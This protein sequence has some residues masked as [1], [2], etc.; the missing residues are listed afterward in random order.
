[1]MKNILRFLPVA[2]LFFGFHAN[3]Q[4][5]FA[6]QISVPSGYAP[7]EAI[8]PPSPLTTQVLFVGGVDL[9]QTTPTYGNPAG[10]A[11]AKEWHDFIGFTPDTDGGNS[12]LRLGFC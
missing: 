9:V 12:R 7:T 10:V 5:M 3:S 6:D 8:M 1:M 4:V 11:I 2:L